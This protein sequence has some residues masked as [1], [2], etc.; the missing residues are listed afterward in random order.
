PLSGYR[1]TFGKAVPG[2]V[3]VRVCRKYNHPGTLCYGEDSK[4]VCEEFSGQADS[5]GC[6][7]EVVK[8]KGFQLKRAGYENKIQVEA[9]I[10]EA[11]TGMKYMYLPGQVW[12]AQDCNTR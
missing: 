3:S 10:K 4:A 12:G 11:E 2:F 7:S 8:T 5:Q 1:Y 9:K 6:I